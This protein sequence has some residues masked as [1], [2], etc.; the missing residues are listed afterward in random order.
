MKRKNKNS[1]EEIRYYTVLLIT[2][3]HEILGHV[4]VILQ[5]NLYDKNIR[6]PET[7]NS[8][9]SKGV[10]KRGYE[11][12]EYLH[13]ELFGHLLKNLSIEEICFIFD[14]NNYKEE[15]YLQFQ[16]KFL[17]C[18]NNKVKIP[19]ILSGLIKENNSVDFGEINLN[20]Y[21]SKE[22]DDFSINLL[23]DNVRICN[24][25]DLLDENNLE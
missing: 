14:I 5:R 2:F 4:L 10:R 24:T 13:A 19:D 17:N 20:I 22:N 7:K 21:L 16:K 6:S 11:S 8:S 23:D 9:F 3:L 18:K 1:K 12:G 15:N 25:L